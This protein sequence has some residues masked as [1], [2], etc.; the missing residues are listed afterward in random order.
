[1]EPNARALFFP[2][3][4]NIH[5][6][7]SIINFAKL[8]FAILDGSADEKTG[9]PQLVQNWLELPVNL[10]IIIAGPTRSGIFPVECVVPV[11]VEEQGLGMEGLEIADEEEKVEEMRLFLGIMRE[12]SYNVSE[13]MVKVCRQLWEYFVIEV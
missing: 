3:V 11:V 12:G 1:M 8:P 10:N 7:Q 6:L 13:E 2:G 9:D 5:A 4:L